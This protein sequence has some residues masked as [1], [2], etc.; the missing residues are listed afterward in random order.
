MMLHLVSAFRS[1]G[2][3]AELVL[4]RDRGSRR[5]P[6]DV[7]C[8]V[9][10]GRTALGIVLRLAVYLRRERP[11]ALLSTLAQA[12][13]LAVVAKLLSGTS[14]RVYLR[15]ANTLGVSVRHAG[16]S[17]KAQ[18]LPLLARWCYPRADGIIAVSPGVADD[19]AQITKIDRSRQ[20]VLKN[21]VITPDTFARAN[22]PCS[23][24]WLA[25]HALPVVL[26]VGRLVR[27]KNHALL[28]DSFAMVR[29][30]LPCRL[31]VLGEGPDRTRLAQRVDALGIGEAVSMP[32]YEGNP[33]CYM[34]RADLFVLSSAWEGS[35]NV[36][37]E[38]LACGCPV[39]STDCPSGP[40]QILADGD[41]GLLV[42]P[43]DAAALADAMISALTHP[44]RTELPPHQLRA[45]RSDAVAREYL[46]V[47]S[48]CPANH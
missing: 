37:V 31:I 8:T 4:G 5:A 33:L 36:L 11:D 9:L 13:V 25:D 44:R 1:S 32:G 42:P 26:A 43:G 10:R 18:L 39:V 14:A 28:L 15:E 41:L 40:R 24:P 23:H 35:P 16:R 30:K 48:T 47:L 12:N 45:Y 29:A 7:P 19:L 21:P 17:L 46:R 38:A 27:Q 3:Q 22:A 34:S 6:P 2:V 20:H